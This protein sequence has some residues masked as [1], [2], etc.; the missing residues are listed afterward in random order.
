[1]HNAA[2]AE[3]DRLGGVGIS[4]LSEIDADGDIAGRQFGKPPPRPHYPS[5]MPFRQS[6]N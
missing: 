1:M 3:Y 5:L 6:S 4:L 2:C